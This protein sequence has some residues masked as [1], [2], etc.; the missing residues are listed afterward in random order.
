MTLAKVLLANGIPDYEFLAAYKLGKACSE[1]HLAMRFSDHPPGVRLAVHLYEIHQRTARIEVKGRTNTPNRITQT[2]L[3]HLVDAASVQH[4]TT[5]N[6]C[7]TVLRSTKAV[8]GAQHARSRK[9][10]VMMAYP[11][12][13]GAKA[14][15][16]RRRSRCRLFALVH[17]GAASEKRAG[18][19]NWYWC[20]AG[21]SEDMDH[22]LCRSRVISTCGADDEHG[23]ARR[24][25]SPMGSLVGGV[26][27]GLLRDAN[28]RLTLDAPRQRQEGDP[29]VSALPRREKTATAGCRLGDLA[30]TKIEK[31]CALSREIEAEAGSNENGRFD[32]SKAGLRRRNG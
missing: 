18:A 27:P 17:V 1:A 14:D 25:Q 12:V 9:G 28:P 8:I 30:P 4:L 2:V 11:V 23:W 24:I 13:K 3:A 15:I 6:A 20:E 10:V 7:R 16:V 29:I 22:W 31:Y 5:P 19:V 26:S 21:R 32:N